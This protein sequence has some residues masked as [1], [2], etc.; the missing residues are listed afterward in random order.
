MQNQRGFVGVGVLIAILV[1]V[2]VLGSGAYYIV[3]QASPSR[4]V[5]ENSDS[6]QNSSA[7]T[8]GSN[9]QP[10]SAEPSQIPNR[11]TANWKV[12]TDTQYGFSFKYPSGWYINQSSE[13]FIGFSKSSAT[14]PAR[15]FAAFY[16]TDLNLGKEGSPCYVAPQEY[17]DYY[18][19]GD[20][21]AS[22]G[23][24]PRLQSLQLGQV[25]TIRR[26]GSDEIR[27]LFYTADREIGLILY[28]GDNQNPTEYNT[29]DDSLMEEVIK[30]FSFT[31]SSRFFIKINANTISTPTVN[32]RQ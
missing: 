15:Q 30:T 22:S 10:F 13:T 17:F 32:V 12:Y 20:L 21:R 29:G 1:G 16:I 11:E 18:F 31:N 8:S 6:L 26:L 24:Q 3:R 28:P 27:Y 9:T 19:K 23:N 5:S 14:R 7:K 25:P 4:R 2:A